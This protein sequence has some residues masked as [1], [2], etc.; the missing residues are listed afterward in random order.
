MAHFAHV[1]QQGIVDQVIVIEPDV[2]AA[3]GGWLVDGVFK[4]AAEWIQTSYNTRGNVHYGADGNPDGGAPL[5]K[6][7]AGRGYRY[8]QGRDAFYPQQPFP[9]WKLDETTCTWQAPKPRPSNMHQWDE[10]NQKWV[11]QK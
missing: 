8:D 3:A 7:Y 10:A 4:Q 2:L 1:N 11:L 6:N 5:R 9:S